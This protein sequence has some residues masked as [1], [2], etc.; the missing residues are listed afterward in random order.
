MAVSVVALA[1]ALGAAPQPIPPQ[2]P[3]VVF[4]GDSLTAGLGLAEDQ[5][6]PAHVAAALAAEGHPIRM[7]NAGVSGDTTAG[8]LTRLGWLLKQHPDVVVVE[9]G[10]NDGLRGAPLA[11]IEDNLRQ[12]IERIRASGARVLL[13]GMRIPTN[14]GP[15]YTAAFFALYAKLARELHVEEVPFLLEGVGGH[16]ELTLPDGLHPTAAGHEIVAK[17]VLPYLRK[18]LGEPPPR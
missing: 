8:G 11:E 6:W 5:A 4:L 17:T 9:L 10:G 7:V 3:L 1:G 18:V 16:P 2:P 13:C 14:Y 12:I 15:E